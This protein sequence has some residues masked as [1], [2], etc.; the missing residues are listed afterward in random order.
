MA[1]AASF[2]PVFALVFALALVW[3]EAAVPVFAQGRGAPPAPR[4]RPSGNTNV[5]ANGHAKNTGH[6]DEKSAAHEP[7]GSEPG[8]AS[9]ATIRARPMIAP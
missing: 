7:P 1:A 2:A 9:S 5:I 6:S 4:T 3:P 8:C